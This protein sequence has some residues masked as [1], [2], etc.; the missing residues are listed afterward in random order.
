MASQIVPF[1]TVE[2]RACF[3]PSREMW[4]AP[5]WVIPRFSRRSPTLAHTTINKTMHRVLNLN[6]CSCDILSELVV[7]AGGRGPG[8]RHHRL[9]RIATAT[10]PLNSL[11]PKF[12]ELHGFVVEALAFV[13]IPEGFADDAPGDAG[14]EI[15]LVIETAHARHH[16]RFG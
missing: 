16:L 4:T 9:R 14:A 12:Q 7:S 8:H 3:R 5:I 1:C 15:I 2:R 10:R 11:R 13:A 6:L